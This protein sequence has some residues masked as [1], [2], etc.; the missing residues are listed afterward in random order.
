[1]SPSHAHACD[2]IVW[3][4]NPSRSTVDA[5]GGVWTGNREEWNNGLGS[6]VHI[7]LKEL[8]QCVD[9]NGD[10]KITTSVVRGGPDDG[11]GGGK[12]RVEGL[13]A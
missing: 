10:G 7:G 2:P 13:R 8:N 6:M 4:R 5:L 1:M 3:R 9:R 12:G 11:G